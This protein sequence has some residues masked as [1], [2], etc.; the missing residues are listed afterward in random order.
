MGMRRVSIGQSVSRAFEFL[1]GRFFQIVGL[2]WLPAAIYGGANYL[3]WQS[4]GHWMPVGQQTGLELGQ[5]VFVSLAMLAVA[6]MVQSIAAVALTQEALGVR[7]DFALAHLVIGPREARLFGALV[8]FFAAFFVLY[9]TWLLLTVLAIYEVR[10]LAGPGSAVAVATTVR[11]VALIPFGVGTLSLMLFVTLML[12]IVRLGFF[13]APIASVEETV[14]LT[15][16]WELSRGSAWSL[17]AVVLS[18]LLPVIAIASVATW[19]LAGGDLAVIARGVMADKTHGGAAV[20]NFEMAHALVLAFISAG[21][22]ALSAA[23]QSGAS[24]AAYRSVTGHEEGDRADDAALVVPLL[25]PATELPARA[26]DGTAPTPTD[27]PAEVHHHVAQTERDETEAN[28]ATTAGGQNVGQAVDV[29][30]NA[31]GRAHA[32]HSEAPHSPELKHV[33]A[34]DVAPPDEHGAETQ[35]GPMHDA[36]GQHHGEGHSELPHHAAPEDSVLDTQDLPHVATEEH[37]AA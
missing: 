12:S 1:F 22:F 27:M 24:A 21:I 2:T 16:S 20:M 9:S 13:L 37:V 29:C 35:V 18:I 6:L 15:R 8:R 33:A 10:D 23:L 17:L 28:G 3:R 30:P 11:G 34:A 14:T 19:L 4:V 31:D 25:A 36:H 5:A 26:D 7:K 32:S